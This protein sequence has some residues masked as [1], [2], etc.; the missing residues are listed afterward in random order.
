MI[1]EANVATQRR[2]DLQ[3]RKRFSR[4]RKNA[5]QEPET[6]ENE[7]VAGAEMFN[8]SNGT[9]RKKP[10]LDMFKRKGKE[11]IQ[12]VSCPMEMVET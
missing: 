11:N 8:K 12:D 10:C 6:R 4:P 5:N 3:D 9:T 7:S 1:V 2:T